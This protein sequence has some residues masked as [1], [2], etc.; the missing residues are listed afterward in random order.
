VRDLLHDHADGAIVRSV[1]DLGRRFRVRTVAEGVEDE[2]TLRRLADGGV[3]MAQ[4]FHIGRPLAPAEL[5]A[6]LADRAERRAAV[7]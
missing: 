7:A 2:A 6:W 5:E 1:I 3:T 4:G